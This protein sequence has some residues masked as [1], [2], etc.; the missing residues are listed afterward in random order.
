MKYLLDTWYVAAWGSELRSGQLLARRFL[1][2]PVVLYRESGGSVRALADRCP[3]RQAPLRMGKLDGDIL[4][5][6]YHGLAFNGLGECVRNP[7]GS[8]PRAARV[9]TYPLLERHGMLWIWMGDPARADEH[10]IPDFSYQDP[11]QCYAGQRY[12]HVRA[13]YR[14]EI[15][16]I[17][18]LSHIAFLHPTTLGSAAVSKGEFESAQEGNTVWSKRSTTNDVVPDGLADAMG[19]PHGAP[20]D[21]WMDVRWE[22]PAN[23]TL[24]AGGVLAGRP[25]AEGRAVTQAHCFTPETDNTSH[26]WFS[27]CFPRAMGEMGAQLAEAQAD[28]IKVPF[29]TE[30]LPMLE[31]QQQNLQDPGNERSF[32]LAGDAAGVRALRVL[33]KLI[34]GESGANLVAIR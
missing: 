26:Y 9:Q 16:N 21:R 23:M 12:L 25:R 29:E 18:D 22:A 8:V 30:D 1:N 24:Y 7:H 19:V 14:L 15:E 27:I 34:A 13:N 3:H 11:E 33:D 5:C 20:L 2:I 6:G 32:L 4:Q 17:L 28:W 31:A 10:R